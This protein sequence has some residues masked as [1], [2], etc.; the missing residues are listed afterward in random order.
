[1]FRD[2]CGDI[3]DIERDLAEAALA[4]SLGSTEASYHRRTAVERRRSVMTQYAEWLNG[5]GVAKVIALSDCRAS[6]TRKKA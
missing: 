4:H 6:R 5:D 3:G 2:W 1:M